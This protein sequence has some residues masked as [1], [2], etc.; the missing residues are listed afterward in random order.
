MENH[1]T[2]LAG[3]IFFIVFIFT[4]LQ[5]SQWCQLMAIGWCSDGGVSL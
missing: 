2:L 3:L 5:L 1:R 4:D